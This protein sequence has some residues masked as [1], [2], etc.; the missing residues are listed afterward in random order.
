MPRFKHIGSSAEDWRHDN[1]NYTH[2]ECSIE[3]I[4]EKQ[5]SV[6]RHEDMSETE[7]IQ[8]NDSSAA[9]W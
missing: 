9:M 1:I 7:G 4:V 8:N 5:K 3:K 2:S 6:V